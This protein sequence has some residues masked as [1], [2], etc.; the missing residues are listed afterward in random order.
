[1]RLSRLD[2]ALA[3]AADATAEKRLWRGTRTSRSSLPAG[4]RAED[5]LGIGS[6]VEFFPA[7]EAARRMGLP[8]EEVVQLAGEGWLD[9]RVRNGE[10]Y[11]LPVV[12]S[13]M[14]VRDARV[15]PAETPEP[16]AVFPVVGN[17]PEPEPEGLVAFGRA[18]P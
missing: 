9:A 6:R 18:K 11:V 3:S 7:P 5:R 2:V 1:V 8:L 16:V 13:R 4:W 10:L 15:P 17:E 12:L 14:A